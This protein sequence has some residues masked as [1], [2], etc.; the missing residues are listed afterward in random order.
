M[1][2]SWFRHGSARRHSPLGSGIHLRLDGAGA[3]V[4]FRSPGR[5]EVVDGELDIENVAGILGEVVVSG[6]AR[7]SL[8]GD[9]TLSNMLRVD[10]GTLKVAGDIVFANDVEVLNGGSLDVSGDWQYQGGFLANAASVAFDLGGTWSQ[11][12]PLVAVNSNV[13]LTGQVTYLAMDRFSVNKT[14]GAFLMA[15]TLE[16][17]L[18]S[19]ILFEGTQTLSGTGSIEFNL[20][21]VLISNGVLTNQVNWSVVAGGDVS[22]DGRQII[23]EA[24]IRFESDS[25]WY[26]LLSGGLVNSGRTVFEQGAQLNLMNGGGWEQLANGRVEWHLPA[27]PG[28]PNRPVSSDA[29]ISLAGVLE[30]VGIP[31]QLPAMGQDLVFLQSD[32]LTGQFDSLVSTTTSWMRSSGSSWANAKATGTRSTCTATP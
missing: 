3:P 1:A 12:A 9:F 11:A 27:A 6:I 19:G 7:T 2:Q 16:V 29:P 30:I 10:R 22:L 4:E 5:I 28:L 23:N 8:L 15:G 21:T 18:F 20:F 14:G 32:D 31:G 24:T 26:V 13:S 17:D 25:I